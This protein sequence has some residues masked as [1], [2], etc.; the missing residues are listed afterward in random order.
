MAESPRDADDW[1]AQNAGTAPP[2][3]LPRFADLLAAVR[4]L[5]IV[6]TTAP[7]TTVGVSALFYPLVGVLLSVLWL[8][9][10]RLSA[11]SGQVLASVAV[12]ALTVLASGARPLLGAGRTIAAL[13]ARSRTGADE[14]LH[15]TLA[16]AAFIGALLV[17][18]V[19]LLSL[20]ALDH[21]RPLALACAPLLGRWGMVVLAFGSLAARPDGRRVK[22]APALT[23]R[24]FG[25]ASTVTF[26]LIFSAGGIVG[27][28]L[29]L[30]TAGS[31]IGLRILLHSRFGGVSN[32]A[33]GAACELAQL[34]P[35]AL[36]AAF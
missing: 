31:L 2:A 33:L 21:L 28:A 34:V 13:T 24:E 32:A 1:S 4:E 23:F 10:D 18:A 26:A 8:A 3:A 20:I 36:L 16:P 29:V 30:V 35:V 9:V 25:I 6:G 15:G 11:P 7:A 27:I 17:L 5:T 22:F 14:H 12:L 19:E